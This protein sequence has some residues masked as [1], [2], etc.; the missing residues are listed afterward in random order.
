MV[1][2]HW[3]DFCRNF[4]WAVVS[5]SVTED[6]K[7]TSHCASGQLCNALSQGEIP[8]SPQLLFGDHSGDTVSASPGQVS[9]L[10]I[11]TSEHLSYETSLE[12]ALSTLI[13]A[14]LTTLLAVYPFRLLM[15]L[16][17]AY[18][19]Y[20]LGKRAGTSAADRWDSHR[21]IPRWPKQLCFPGV[22][23]VM[24]KSITAREACS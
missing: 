17:P 24:T 22:G 18:P 14:V 5:T 12:A 13:T 7:N 21:M 8:S 4:P 11:T 20:C 3:S 10:Q 9:H 19:L 16:L 15:W 23:K 1:R 6:C 2:G